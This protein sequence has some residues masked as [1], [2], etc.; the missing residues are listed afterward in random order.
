[1]EPP[2]ALVREILPLL[3][4]FVVGGYG[5][6][7]G[8]SHAKGSSDALSDV[9][10][11]LFSDGVVPGA[12]RAELVTGALGAAAGA[13]SWGRDDPFV[14]GG[15][16]FACRGV[17]VECWLRSTERVERTVAACRRGEVRRE[18][19]VW[20]VM[21]L[22]DH[23][24]LA[25]LRAM[26]IVEDPEGTLMRWKEEVAAYPEPLRDALLRRFM[27]EAGFWPDN[28][29][30]RTAVERADLLYTSGIVQQVL[31]ALVQVVFALNREYFPGEKGLDRALGELPLLPEAFAARLR[32]L[33]FPGA[34]PGVERLREQRRELAALVAE[35]RRLVEADGGA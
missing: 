3:R 18:Y 5:I 23:V 9:D 22:F 15:T 8:G 13:V 12:R 10:V 6:A 7:L 25:D 35:V 31:H 16:D 21:G 20:T 28:F 1:M 11:Y 26:R 33:L 2:G 14:E 29:H 32:A 27:A 24:A 17:R 34:E 30:Y 19:A 4:G